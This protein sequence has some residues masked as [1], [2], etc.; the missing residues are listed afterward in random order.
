[1]VYDGKPKAATVTPNKGVADKGVADKITVKYYTE[2]GSEVDRPTDAGTYTVKIDVEETE[3]YQAATD[4]T[5]ND[6]KFTIA[7]AKQTISVPQDKTLVK[8]GA[9]VD[10]SQW[11]SVSGVEG[12]SPAGELRYALNGNSPGVTLTGSTLTA[13]KN[14]TA[15]TVTIKVTAAETQNYERAEA[16]F[17]VTV[18][19]KSTETLTHV[20]MTG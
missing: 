17:T 12:G 8:N 18:A 10:I 2:N 16:T 5:A 7:K 4:L 14:A 13:E 11:V 1:M 20:N 19:A 15:N 3:S 6:W 9:G